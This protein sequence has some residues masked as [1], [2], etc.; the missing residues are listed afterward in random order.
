L[1]EKIDA[2]WADLL[3]NFE[4]ICED[5]VEKFDNKDAKKGNF[6]SRMEF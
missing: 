2:F 1:T 4:S 5:M 3:A 6:I